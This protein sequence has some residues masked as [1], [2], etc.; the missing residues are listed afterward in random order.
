[1]KRIVVFIAAILILSSCEEVISID[2][3]DGEPKL[4]IDAEIHES[5]ENRV[6]L[7]MTQALDN[8]NPIAEVSGA[9]VTIKEPGGTIYT[10]TEGLTGVYTM[11]VVPQ[12]TGTYEL[13]VIN[14]GETNTATGYMPSPIQLDSLTQFLS[15]GFFGGG[16]ETVITLNY[17]DPA[18]AT[19]YYKMKVWRGFVR[20]DDIYYWDD[21]FFNGEV[22][23]FPLFAYGWKPSDTATIQLISM[24][25]Y[26]Y[27]YFKVLGE[28]QNGGGGAFATTP[29]NPIS[30]INGN[31]IGVFGAYA[32]D[33]DTL[34]VNP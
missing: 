3:K 30:N 25:E 7:T 6:T 21:Q 26:A 16:P 27:E 32:S 17:V 24:D 33:L 19:N 12:V 20:R 1:M 31:A 28:G 15:P 8:S 18:G 9:T 10:L 5:G 29:G 14:N 34:Y 11:P 22:V 2:Y 13:T 4:V 23:D